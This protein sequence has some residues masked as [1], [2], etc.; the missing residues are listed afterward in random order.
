MNI[1]NDELNIQIAI[2]KREQVEQKLQELENE[3]SKVV[4][5]YHNEILDKLADYNN[6]QYEALKAKYKTTDFKDLDSVYY[7]HCQSGYIFLCHH[8][9]SNQLIL[10]SPKKILTVGVN[11]NSIDD[12]KLVSIN[13]QTS[14]VEYSNVGMIKHYL[15]L[16]L[17]FD[18]PQK[19]LDI[20]HLIPTLDEFKAKDNRSIFLAGIRHTYEL[21]RAKKIPGTKFH[22]LT[23]SKFNINKQNEMLSTCTF[24]NVIMD[25]KKDIEGIYSVDS[26]IFD[27]KLA[28]DYFKLLE[29][30]CKDYVA[31]EVYKKLTTKKEEMN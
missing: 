28:T 25:V 4:D 26:F 14:E 23:F 3:K 7:A 9:Y 18:T 5:E 11:E 21:I 15:M 2:G 31:Q 12:W 19:K 8:E 22:S 29:I 30:I 17:M 24:M 27:K 6:N 20:D 1:T 13:L 10:L 16:K